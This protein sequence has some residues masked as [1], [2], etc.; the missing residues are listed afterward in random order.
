MSIPWGYC[1]WESGHF[2]LDLRLVKAILSVPPAL[3]CGANDLDAIAL[4]NTIFASVK[5]KFPKNGPKMV[6]FEVLCYK[7]PVFCIIVVQG[8]SLIVEKVYNW[9]QPIIKIRFRSLEL[10]FLTIII[11]LRQASSDHHA[12]PNM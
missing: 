10:Y 1:I 5:R 6:F 12:G 11:S 2:T 7:K 3:T 8:G 9:K 4:V